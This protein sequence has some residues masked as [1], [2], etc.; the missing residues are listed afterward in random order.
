MLELSRREFLQTLAAAYGATVMGCKR[1]PAPFAQEH[2]CI[3]IFGPR[4][5]I[6]APLL[7]ATPPPP[8]RDLTEE[9][10]EIGLPELVACTTRTKFLDMFQYFWP[11]S[12]NDLAQLEE[13]IEIGYQ[14]PRI[15]GAAD[16]GDFA[17]FLRSYKSQ[18]VQAGASSAAVFVYNEFTRHWA[19]DVIAACRDAQIAEFVLFKDPTRAP[20][21]CT[22][23]AK[24]KG[25]KRP[26]P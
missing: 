15:R 19:P 8:T 18:S 21:L 12:R 23:P 4:D 11:F 10:F 16:A 26:P 13:S 14:R 25:F 2:V 24:Q 17:G 9:Y 22:F 5:P 20:Y 3:H 1:T 6:P 7:E